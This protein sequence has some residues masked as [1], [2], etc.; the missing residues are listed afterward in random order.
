MSEWRRNPRVKEIIPIHWK[1][2]RQ[3][4]Q[5]EGVIRNISI[6]GLMVEVDEHFKPTD[7]GLFTLDVVSSGMSHLIPQ[8]VKLVW[9]SRVMADKMRQFCGMKFVHATGPVLT[10]LVEHVEGQLSVF[11]GAMDIN[12][13]QN[14]LSQSN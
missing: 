1:M 9:Y 7:N 6:S 10:R 3:E 11:Q 14:Y 8:D 5:G 13:I 2:V 4:S 12:I